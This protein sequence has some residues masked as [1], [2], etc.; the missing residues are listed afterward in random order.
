[1]IPIAARERVAIVERRYTLFFVIAA[2][3]D[4]LF[5]PRCR[6]LLARGRLPV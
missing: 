3:A 1:M 6:R 2:D 4:V 5:M